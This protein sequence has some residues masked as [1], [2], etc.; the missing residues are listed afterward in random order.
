MSRAWRWGR[1]TA[2]ETHSGRTRAAAALGPPLP[3]RPAHAGVSQAESEFPTPFRAAPRSAAN[4][5]LRAL[6]AAGRL[7]SRPRPAV[8]PPVSDTPLKAGAAGNCSSKH[9]PRARRR[10]GERGHLAPACSPVSACLSRGAPGPAD[11]KR[12]LSQWLT[13]ERLGVQTY[14]LKGPKECLSY[15]CA[16]EGV[17]QLLMR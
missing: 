17:P 8:T 10:A 9:V 5:L 6:R 7:C 3:G 2:A 12:C 1:R 11:S 16:N 14:L 4:R 15:S 13:L